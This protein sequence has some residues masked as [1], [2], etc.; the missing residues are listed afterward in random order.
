MC[1]CMT[2][3]NEHLAERNTQL[4]PTLAIRDGQFKMLGA[5]LATQKIDKSK[6]GQP[7]NVIAAYCPFCGVKYDAGE[8]APTAKS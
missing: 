4:T 1:D 3:V 6:R 7:S 2:K 8:D 5:T